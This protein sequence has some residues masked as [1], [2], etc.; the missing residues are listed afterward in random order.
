[1]PAR[2]KPK[3]S[4]LVNLPL[5]KARWLEERSEQTGESMTH[6]VVAALDAEMK[7]QARIERRAQ[8]EA[9]AQ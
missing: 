6:H 2:A 5:D 3:K 7:R 9:G 4:M 8:R 1:M